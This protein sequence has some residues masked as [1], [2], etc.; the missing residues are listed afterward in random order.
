MVERSPTTGVQRISD[1]VGSTTN[2]LHCTCSDFPLALL[3]PAV[4]HERFIHR[5]GY[6]Q[7]RRNSHVWSLDNPHAATETFAEPLFG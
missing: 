2:W 6:V 5:R 3:K 7:Q 1:R 4:P